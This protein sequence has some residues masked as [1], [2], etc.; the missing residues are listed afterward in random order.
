ML[1]IKRN[2]L[3]VHLMFN[4][5]S[6]LDDLRFL[7]SLGRWVLNRDRSFLDIGHG[8]VVFLV[9]LRLT[10]AEHGILALALLSCQPHSLKLLL[11][12]SISVL[13]RHW[14]CEHGRVGLVQLRLEG[15]LLFIF[16]EVIVFRTLFGLIDLP[17]P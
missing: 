3:F 5:A 16:L 15:E 8:V 7:I 13:R 11:L 17:F 9:D 12:G 4:Q 2:W 1:E 6:C 14:L 10:T